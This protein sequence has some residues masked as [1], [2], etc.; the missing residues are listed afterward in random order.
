[1]VFRR[2]TTLRVLIL[3]ASVAFSFSHLSEAFASCSSD[4]RH[5]FE[6]ET[7]YPLMMT[8]LRFSTLATTLVAWSTENTSGQLNPAWTFSYGLAWVIGAF[9]GPSCAN[10]PATYL[11]GIAIADEKTALSLSRS[12]HLKM[13]QELMASYA[14]SFLVLAGV[15]I[16]NE[17]PLVRT[18]AYISAFSPLIGFGIFELRRILGNKERRSA[19][20]HSGHPHISFA[21]KPDINQHHRYTIGF[22]VSTP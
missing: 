20:I 3:T 22:T 14:V 1:M 12:D 9:E 6:N 17:T 5:V 11:D 8:S 21:L 16:D 15:H 19:G 7:P 18:A 13:V 10:V 4:Q 2:E